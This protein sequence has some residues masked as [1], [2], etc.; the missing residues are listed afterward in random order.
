MKI[1]IFLL[2]HLLICLVAS[3]C[4]GQVSRI[5]TLNSLRDI[6]EFIAEYN[7]IETDDFSLGYDY[8]FSYNTLSPEAC[9][10]CADSL[11]IYQ[12]YVKEDLDHNGLTDLLVIGHNTF[13]TGVFIFMDYGED[14]ILLHSLTLNMP[15]DCSLAKIIHQEEETQ[16]LY[17]FGDSKKRNKKYPSINEGTRFLNQKLFT[18]KFGSWIEYNP[19]P[20]ILHLKKIQFFTSHGHPKKIS[21]LIIRDDLN[22]EVINYYPG[23]K[24]P[25]SMRKY[26]S[27]IK[28]KD[29]RNYQPGK[30][31]KPHT[32]VY[33][34]MDPVDSTVYQQIV[35]L[36]N[37][38]NFSQDPIFVTDKKLDAKDAQS[39]R[40]T[41]ENGQEYTI[42]LP[43][44]FTSNHG[45]RQL[46]YLI[47][48]VFR[49]SKWKYGER[50]PIMPP[51]YGY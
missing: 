48:R 7:F 6:E 14:S 22:A 25:K 29:D 17:Y 50:G 36:I 41:Y 34:R 3:P 8:D 28:Y 5:D 40:I 49:E 45:L 42:K 20:G 9:K 11:G 24:I 51:H 43:Y 27:P 47:E 12:P 26:T 35:G 30:R 18:F 2:T 38:I 46:A 37:Y 39:L 32:K 1:P 4:Y 23:K 44:G 15:A 21:E 10:R 31:I 13:R 33:M 16:V 19:E